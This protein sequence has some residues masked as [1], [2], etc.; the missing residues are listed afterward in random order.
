MSPDK[1]VERVEKLLRLAAPRSGST[2]PERAS[3]AL[4]AAKLIDEHDLV[5]SREEKRRKREASIV[6][7]DVWFMSIALD[8]C[9][10]SACSELISKGDHVWTRVVRAGQAEYRHNM[11]PCNMIG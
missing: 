2:E 1:I 10:C 11:V 3:A 9:S 5:V 8:F 4:E 6:M 7:K